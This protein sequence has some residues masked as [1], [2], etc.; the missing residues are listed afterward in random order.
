MKTLFDNFYSHYNIW[1]TLRD[2]NEMNIGK[3]NFKQIDKIHR[4]NKSKKHRKENR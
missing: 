1:D 2:K 3:R 4:K